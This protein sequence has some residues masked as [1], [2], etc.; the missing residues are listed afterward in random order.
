MLLFWS[1]GRGFCQ[2]MVADVKALEARTKT[3][4]LLK[5]GRSIGS[6]AR[7]EGP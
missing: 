6:S 2:Q 5:I 4:R 7:A 1:P 3:N